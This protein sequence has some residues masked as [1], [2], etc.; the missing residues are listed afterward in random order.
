MTNEELDFF[1]ADTG[2]KRGGNDFEAVATLEEADVMYY[3]GFHGARK[4]DCTCGAGKWRMFESKCGNAER[5]EH[6]HNQLNGST[7]GEPVRYYRTKAGK[8]GEEKALYHYVQLATAASV[9][10]EKNGNT[11][12]SD[13]ERKYSAWLEYLKVTGKSL[14]HAAP[15]FQCK[16]FQDI[17]AIGPAAIPFVIDK[18][19]HEEEAWLLGRAVEEMARMRLR[20]KYNK[21]KSRYV[22]QRFQDLD[23]RVQNP[24]LYWWRTA[25]SETP[26]MFEDIY[27]R[28]R[29]AKQERNSQEIREAWE[30]MRDIGLDVLPLAIVKINKGEKELIPFIPS[31]LRKEVFSKDATREEVLNWWRENELRYKIPSSKEEAEELWQKLKA[32]EQDKKDSRDSDGEDQKQDE[33][34]DETAGQPEVGDL[35][36]APGGSVTPGSAKPEAEPEKAIEHLQ[37]EP[38]QSGGWL[39]VPG[40]I[41]AG[42][43]IAGVVLFLLLRR[44]R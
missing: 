3:S 33:K 32:M 28:W 20:R 44:R 7:Y 9:Q 31:V 30:E 42:V 4:K 6:V 2:S 16:Q 26:K 40:L 24:Y 15:V 12:E 25:R 34:R 43:V 13:F 1:Y 29:R 39:F 37:P 14:S 35:K 36:R 11:L 18:I 38:E 8:Y 10:E 5:I 17:T 41:A 21:E 23:E 19:G 27:A 22:Y